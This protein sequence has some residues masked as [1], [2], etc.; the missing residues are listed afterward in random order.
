M[1]INNV[2]LA[3]KFKNYFNNNEKSKLWLESFIEKNKA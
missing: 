1:G 3:N 2:N